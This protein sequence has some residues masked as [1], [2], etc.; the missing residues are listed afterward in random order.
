[1]GCRAPD[2]FEMDAQQLALAPDARRYT[3]S[4]MSY[5]SMAGLSAALDVLLDLGEETCEEHSRSLAGLLVEGAA[6][7]DWAPFRA[8]DDAAAAPHII[9]LR[10]PELEAAAVVRALHS[11]GIV[12]SARNDRLRVSLAPYNDAAD[13]EAL[14]AALAKYSKGL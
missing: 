2:P 10:H 4:T 12:C 5:I 11:D 3:Q 1:M 14:L 13:V 6:E 9:A 8:L 7:H